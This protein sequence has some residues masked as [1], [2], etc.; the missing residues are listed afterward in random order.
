MLEVLGVSP[1]LRAGLVNGGAITLRAPS[2]DSVHRFP[3]DMQRGGPTLHV[4]GQVV[5][6][7]VTQ[8]FPQVLIARPT[9]QRLG[10][11]DQPSSMTVFV[12]PRPLPKSLVRRVNELTLDFATAI[13][14][15]PSWSMEPSPPTTWVFAGFDPWGALETTRGPVRAGGFAAM[16]LFVLAV[17]G[18]G[19]ALS[20]RD[21]EDE[22]AVFVAV[23]GG[24]GAQRRLGTRRASLLVGIAVAVAVPVALA[25]TTAVVMMSTRP[26][27]Q[28]RFDWFAL[29]AVSIALPIVVALATAAGGWLRDRMSP[30]MPDALAFAD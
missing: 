11:S 6:D 23:G 4:V 16:A 26:G 21:A 8:A 12:E 29:V 28:L 3:K 18:V 15:R 14:E 7:E 17:V 1:Q 20:A 10:W 25:A 9:A 22:R 30:S 24:P 5:S 13:G 27:V 19:L 2:D